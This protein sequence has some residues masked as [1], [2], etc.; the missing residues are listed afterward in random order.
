MILT[1]NNKL[2]TSIVAINELPL[3]AQ[4]ALRWSEIAEKRKTLPTDEVVRARLDDA[5]MISEHLSTSASEIH[6][7]YNPR[8]PIPFAFYTCS[9]QHDEI[10][11]IAS[12]AIQKNEIKLSLL[13]T[14]PINLFPLDKESPVK[15]VGKEILFHIIKTACVLQIGTIAVH[16]VER[17]KPFYKALGFHLEDEEDPVPSRMVLTA[18]TIWDR[19][20][21]LIAPNFAD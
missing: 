11:A 2:T 17:E 14:N 1:E 18:S 20:A 12:V 19:Y 8:K 9:D 16:P 21:H 7:T 6:R 13:T 4:T 3:L 5:A 10:Q 15:G